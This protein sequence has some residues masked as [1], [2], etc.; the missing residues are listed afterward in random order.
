MLEAQVLADALRPLIRCKMRHQVHAFN[1]LARAAGIVSIVA[2]CLWA[3]RRA[4]CAAP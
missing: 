3:S 1:R 2:I 4:F